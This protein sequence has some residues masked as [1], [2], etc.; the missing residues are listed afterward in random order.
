MHS[1]DSECSLC[2]FCSIGAETDTCGTKH[3]R[4]RKDSFVCLFVFLPVLGRCLAVQYH[5][6]VQK[7]EHAVK[8]CAVWRHI[9]GWWQAACFIVRTWY[10]VDINNEC[11]YCLKV[12]LQQKL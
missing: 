11:K 4:Q 12:N 2:C 7:H 5:A 6:E 1:G 3:G 8:L 10:S 9:L